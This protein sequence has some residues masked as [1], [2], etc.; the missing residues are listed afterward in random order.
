MKKG[1]KI[2]C[3]PELAA[4]SIEAVPKC[5]FMPLPGVSESLKETEILNSNNSCGVAQSTFQNDNAKAAFTLA[6]VLITLGIIGIV[7][8]M[9]L[10][11]LIQ[12]HNKQV[13]ETR[14]KKFYSTIN[15]A[16]QLTEVDYG[17]KQYLYNEFRDICDT[18]GFAADSFECSEIIFN[19][20]LKKYIKTTGIKKCRGEYLCM[21]FSDG[22]TVKISY[23]GRDYEYY[24]NGKALTDPKSGIN[25]FGFAFYPTGAAGLRGK[26]FINKGVEP[27]IYQAWDGTYEGLKSDGAYAKLIQLNGWRVPDDYPLKF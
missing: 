4:K 5:D 14:L 3:H 13:V 15:Q 8:A 24:I 2:N 18:N 6:E 21:Y 25:K 17:D 22:S 10:P 16:I 12:K 11:A 1:L 27:Y 23:Y 19:K 20:Y 26:H 7:A 9:T